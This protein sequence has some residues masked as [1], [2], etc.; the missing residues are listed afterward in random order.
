MPKRRVRRREV[1]QPLDKEYRY[2]PL[3]QNQFAIVDAAD[4]DWLNQWNWF[5]FWHEKTRGFYARRFGGHRKPIWMHRLILNCEGKEQGDHKNRNTLDNRRN[6][7]RKATDFQ[8][9][10][11]RGIRKTNTSGYKG[12]SWVK[13]DKKWRAAMGYQYK[14]LYLGYFNSPEEAARAYDAA[15]MK[16]HGEFARLN[17]NIQTDQ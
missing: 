14:K 1:V 9:K 3:T 2:L 11:N 13:K 8:N 16:Y 6:N 17:F 4:F 15:A 12:V 5:A 7:L 10:A